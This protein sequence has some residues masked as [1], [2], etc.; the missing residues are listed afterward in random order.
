MSVVHIVMRRCDTKSVFYGDQHQE[1]YIKFNIIMDKDLRLCYHKYK[2]RAI[3][4]HIVIKSRVQMKTRFTAAALFICIILSIPCGCENDNKS[5]ESSSAVNE[6]TVTTGE[7]GVIK[8]EEYGGIMI[9]LTVEGFNALG[10]AYGDSVD[11]SFDNGVELYD[12]PYYTG[13]CVPIDELLLC[14]YP[15]SAYVKLARNYGDPTWEEFHMTE[16]SKVNVTMNEKAKYL[17]TEELHKLEYSD[18]RED[19]ESD[20]IFANFREVKGGKLREKGFYRFHLLAIISTTARV[21]PM[22]SPRNTASD[23][24]SI[25]PI[26]KQNTRHIPKRMIL[27]L[28]TMTYF[29]GTE[30]FCCST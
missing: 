16:D 15:G 29:I 12:I 23:S 24:L 10:F 8:D 7:I 2:V 17:S 25:C 4:T 5:S 19:Y 11:I 27:N 22:R 6:Q 20:I 18:E 28:R 9:D 3:L 26:T 30:T 1:S 21:M 14:A 13:Y